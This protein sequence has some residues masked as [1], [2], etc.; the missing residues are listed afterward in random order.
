MGDALH[1]ESELQQRVETG[2]I[3]GSSRAFPPAPP[4]AVTRQVKEPLFRRS[5]GGMSSTFRGGGGGVERGGGGLL[6]AAAAAYAADAIAIS[7]CRRKEKPT[8]VANNWGSADTSSP[9]HDPIRP[10]SPAW[11]FGE[12][13][14]CSRP[15]SRVDSRRWIDSRGGSPGGSPGDFRERDCTDRS[16]GNGIEHFSNPDEEKKRVEET[17]LLDYTSLGRQTVSHRVTSPAHV[18]SREGLGS[19]S[20]SMFQADKR[21]EP[22]PGSFKPD[23]TATSTHPG[24]RCGVVMR[25]AGSKLEIDSRGA[26]VTGDIGGCQDIRPGPGHYNLWDAIGRQVLS[27]RPSSPTVVFATGDW[28]LR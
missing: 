9:F 24:P 27:T 11:A 14:G 13:P 7:S 10:K 2:S 16:L 28:E 25:Q 22:G 1:D 20:L 4:E 5:G 12:A 6:S 19:E 26:G 21:P 17:E 3:E 23:L 8:M 18:F 15:R